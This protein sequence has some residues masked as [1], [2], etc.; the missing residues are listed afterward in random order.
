MLMMANPSDGKID[1]VAGKIQTDVMDFVEDGCD[2]FHVSITS[3]EEGTLANNCR[4][5]R[6]HCA[7][8]R[9][10]RRPCIVSCPHFNFTQDA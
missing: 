7:D 8:M 6:F 1:G 4:I 5:F 9:L 2:F 10:P 3:I